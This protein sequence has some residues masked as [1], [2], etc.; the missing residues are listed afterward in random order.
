MASHL[1]RE[2]EIIKKRIL[3]L[4]ALVEEKVRMAVQA[5]ENEDEKVCAQIL[6]SDFEVDEMEVEVEEECL[7]AL[8]LHQPV[9]ID[10]RFLVA[11][12]KIN[13]DLERIGDE[14]VNIAQRI[15]NTSRRKINERLVI[16]V[17]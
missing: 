11:V 4:G 8:A 1:R 7:K 17:G 16:E 6:A 5:I 10:L 2:L 3:Q 13:N 14:A 12:I 15:T 9:A